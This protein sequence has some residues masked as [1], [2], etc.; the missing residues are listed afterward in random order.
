M[1]APHCRL[2]PAAARER[3][4]KCNVAVPREYRKGRQKFNPIA[5]VVIRRTATIPAERSAHP[6][7][8]PRARRTGA[9]PR[10]AASGHS[11]RSKTKIISVR[12]QQQPPRASANP[13]FC[14]VQLGGFQ[15][16]TEG[17][18]QIIC[19]PGCGL[20]GIALLLNR[21]RRVRSIGK[22]QRIPVDDGVVPQPERRSGRGQQ[23]KLR[24]SARPQRFAFAF[25]S[26]H[27]QHRRDH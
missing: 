23:N 4:R 20:L 17:N 21:P 1:T 18:R 15:K 13:A 12:Q 5:N 26:Q 25:R 6:R 7:R 8:R 9:A 11:R 27:H 16:V 19:A 10:A 2:H 14:H 3:Q 22:L 24:E